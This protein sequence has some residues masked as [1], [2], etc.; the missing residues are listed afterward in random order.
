MVVVGVA[1]VVQLLVVEVVIAV[2]VVLEILV[3]LAVVVFVVVL[4]PILTFESLV[5]TFCPNM[6]NI[7]I[8]NSTVCPQI[9]FMCLVFT[10]QPKTIISLRALAD[11]F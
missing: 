6:F 5:V 2:V 7:N 11:L 4:F 3:L 8:N 9:M 10:S 1:I